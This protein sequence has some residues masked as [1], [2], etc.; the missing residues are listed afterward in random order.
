MRGR[1]PVALAFVLTITA[2]VAFAA[3]SILCRLALGGGTIDAYSFTA[4]RL[5]SG[6][7]ALML[8][9]ISK[10]PGRSPTKS[11]WLGAFLL[12]VYALPFSLSYVRLDTGT[13]ALLLFGAVQLTM[14][15]HGLRHRERPRLLEWLGLLGAVGGVAYL[16]SPGLTAPDPIGAALM[17]TA[18]AGWGGYSIVGKRAGE[19][20]SETA[21]NFQRAALLVVPATALAWPWLALSPK[22][23]LL[24][25][26]SGALASG[27]G[28]TVWYAA[29]KHLPLTRAALVQLAV[30]LIAATGGVAF[31][32]ETITL[33]LTLASAVILGSIALGI[34]GPRQRRATT[35]TD[36][37]S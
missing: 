30:P 11:G 12:V 23:A 28:Y 4:I 18:G 25:T 7:L 27:F 15:G 19:A 22:G 20:A 35:A 17:L 33:R 8:L 21:G 13:G 29:L 36:P 37:Q 2:L 6:A 16:V 9:N 24:A 5:G 3:N 1:T 10:Q 26:A 31:A 32:G 14:I 34:V